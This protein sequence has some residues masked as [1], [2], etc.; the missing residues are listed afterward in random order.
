MNDKMLGQKVW[1]PLSGITPISPEELEKNSISKAPR[2]LE[3]ISRPSTAATRQGSKRGGSRGSSPVGG[4]RRGSLESEEGGIGRAKKAGKRPGTAA[5]GPRGRSHS[6]AVGEGGWWDQEGRASQDGGR[7]KLR[8]ARSAN[9]SPVR[10]EK[11][12]KLK[13]LRRRKG[14]YMDFTE[15]YKMNRN[16]AEKD[17]DPFSE[18]LRE[19]DPFSL[20]SVASS[21]EVW[22][23]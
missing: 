9:S 1:A 20:Q 5:V 14:S 6:P 16:A 3:K 18:N 19:P 4:S 15:S 7:K 11:H 21:M 10:A 17:P 2:R 23:V 22:R 12:K 8:A 13:P